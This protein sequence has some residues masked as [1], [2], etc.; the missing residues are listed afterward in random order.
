[1]NIRQMTASDIPEILSRFL[2]PWSTQE[3]TNAIWETYYREQ[4]EANRT[5]AIVEKNGEIVGYGSLLRRS[6][7]PHFASVNMPEVNAIWIDE[8]HR[9]Q[10]VGRALIQWIENLARSEGY[11]QIGIG[12]GLYKDYGPAQRLYFRLGYIPDGKG[13]TYKGQ[14]TVA[15]QTY[16][17]DDD[18]LLW[19]VKV[20][21]PLPKSD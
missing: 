19:L 7:Y 17:L 2:F 10:G 14:A 1:M 15:G 16:P 6:E 9:G 3:Q 13:I 8:S 20:L 11:N 5:V 12:V 18:L 4:Q 21:A